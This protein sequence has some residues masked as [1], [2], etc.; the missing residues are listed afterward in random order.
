[1]MHNNDDQ[2]YHISFDVNIISRLFD[3]K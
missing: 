3:Y 2:Y 1:M